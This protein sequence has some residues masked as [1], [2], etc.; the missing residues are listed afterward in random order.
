MVAHDLIAAPGITSG[1]KG[2]VVVIG[3]VA[4]AA[5]VFAFV[6]SRRC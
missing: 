6:L 2:I 3:L 4:I 1:Q 5:L